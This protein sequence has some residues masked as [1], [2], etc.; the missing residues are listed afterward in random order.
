MAGQ[1]VTPPRLWDPVVRLTH[2]GIA[3]A[4]IGNSLFTAG[5]GFWHVTLGWIGAGL[6]V[7]RLVWGI[8]G[9][10]EARF[11]AFPPNPAAAL[12]HLAEL[13]TGRPRVY[14]SH[15]PAGAMMAYALWLSLAVVVGTG[16]VMTGGASPQAILAQQR[17]LEEG[18]WSQLTA[19]SG[20][21]GE[22]GEEG[23][24]GSALKAVHETFANLMLA[25]A[26]IH[27][28]GVAVESRALRRNLVL[29]MIGGA[30]GERR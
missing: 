27:V 1:S 8:V 30:R 5:G 24:G 25:L 28:A 21:V 15:N 29:P 3:V 20:E 22:D 4:V 9:R 10:K 14:V 16:L 6:L 26:L 2:W 18:D 13:L 11:A 23:E 17:I 7:L 12:R 19:Q